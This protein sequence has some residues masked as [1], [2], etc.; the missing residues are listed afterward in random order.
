M[1]QNLF[2]YLFIS[3]VHLWELLKH[4]FNEITLYW[5]SLNSQRLWQSVVLNSD[6]SSLTVR[7]FFFF[8]FFKS[9]KKVFNELQVKTWHKINC[10][11]R[12]HEIT[13]HLLWKAYTE[14]PIRQKQIVGN[15]THEQVSCASLVCHFLC[16][17][18]MGR[19]MDRFYWNKILLR[20]T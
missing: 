17:G 12:V 18:S 1:I 3:K 19:N 15:P 20:C 16:A 11:D 8:F 4:N 7:F 5:K 2:F 9:R 10:Q 6:A 14:E 13:F